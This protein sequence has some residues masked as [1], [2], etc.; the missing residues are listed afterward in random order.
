MKTNYISDLTLELYHLNALEK[1]ERKFVETTMTVN[2][3]LYARYEALKKSDKEIKNQYFQEKKPTFTL[4]KNIDAEA[5]KKIDKTRNNKLMLGIGI[6]AVFLCVFAVSL[7]YFTGNN[8]V[9]TITEETVI[10][11]DEEIANEAVERIVVIPEEVKETEQKIINVIPNE[12]IGGTHI[13]VL[14]DSPTGVY[15]RGGGETPEQPVITIPDGVSFIFDSMFANRQLTAVVIPERVVFIGDSAFENNLLGSIIIPAN[16]YSI[17]NRA[18]ANNPLIRITI[19]ANVAVE[20]DAIPGNFAV[21]Y[22]SNGMAAG[23]YTRS[24]TNSNEWTKQ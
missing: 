16:V 24:N 20:N 23:T 6:A 4:I 15:I 10:K 7:I 14:P 1:R 2:S 5:S 21:V 3:D 8:T 9:N 22:N 18:F 17:G 19:G 11:E 12:R 13:T